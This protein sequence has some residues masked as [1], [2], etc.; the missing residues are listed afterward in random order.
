[1]YVS[2]KTVTNGF[3]ISISFHYVEETEPFSAMPKP[4]AMA[5]GTAIFLLNCIGRP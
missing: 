5:S 3:G 1:L 2:I 4:A